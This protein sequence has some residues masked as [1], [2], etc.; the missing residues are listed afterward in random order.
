[1]ITDDPPA[2]NA[3]NRPR[4]RKPE[5]AQPAIVIT[6]LGA[7]GPLKVMITHG[8][9]DRDVHKTPEGAGQG[10]L[11]Q[12]LIRQLRGWPTTRIM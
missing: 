4:S 5:F 12:E 9:H 2:E 8:G 7:P 11:K 10:A 1:M 3:S 6:T